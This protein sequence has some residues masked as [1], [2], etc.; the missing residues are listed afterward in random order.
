MIYAAYKQATLGDTNIPRPGMFDQRA[1]YKWDAWNSK[2]GMSQDLAKQEYIS[3]AKDV[4][5]IKDEPAKEEKLIIKSKQTL[6]RS[7]TDPTPDSPPDKR[8]LNDN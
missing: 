7:Q 8:P 6:Q 3:Y 5:G 4:L 2:K 1:R